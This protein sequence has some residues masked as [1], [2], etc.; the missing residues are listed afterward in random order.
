MRIKEGFMIKEVAGEVMAIPFGKNYEKIGAM[1]ALNGTGLFLWRL[2]EQEQTMETLC[3]ALVKEYDID[4]ALAEEATTS[5][6]ALLKSQ[7]LL[8]D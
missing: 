6:L 5:F 3:D 8:E 2:L 4:K 1:I 7:E